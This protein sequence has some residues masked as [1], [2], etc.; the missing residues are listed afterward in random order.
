MEECRGELN[1]DAV[2]AGAA[3]VIIQQVAMRATHS[4]EPVAHGYRRAARLSF[5]QASR[6]A[7][8]TL[9]KSA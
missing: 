4:D 5:N 6:L 1:P 7:R 8:I 3:C 2:A 9:V